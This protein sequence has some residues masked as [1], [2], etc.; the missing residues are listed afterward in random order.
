M[1]TIHQERHRARTM[2]NIQERYHVSSD[3]TSGTGV[4]AAAYL[5]RNF[6]SDRTCVFPVEV[7]AG[8][9]SRKGDNGTGSVGTNSISPR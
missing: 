7:E 2:N 9:R 8:G 1:T 6:G 5:S 3:L 4:D